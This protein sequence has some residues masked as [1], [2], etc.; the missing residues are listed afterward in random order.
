M[1][2]FWDVAPCSLV[3]VC[4][5]FRGTCCLH[6]QAIKEAASTSETSVKF[7]QTTRHYKPEDSLLHTR[8]RENFKSYIAETVSSESTVRCLTTA[9]KSQSG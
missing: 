8:R 7:Y 3:E 1:A 5:R 2:V 9:G 6:Q 4:R